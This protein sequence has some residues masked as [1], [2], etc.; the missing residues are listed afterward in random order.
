[1]SHRERVVEVKIIELDI[2][3][4]KYAVFRC[5][6][7]TSPLADDPCQPRLEGIPAMTT[8]IVHSLSTNAMADKSHP[9]NILAVPFKQMVNADAFVVIKEKCYKRIPDG[10][11]EATTEEYASI[12]GAE[13]AGK[14]V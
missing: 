9:E 1:M 11:R 5:L 6:L 14:R 8:E 3:T 12:L 7:T 13:I 2:N 10:F 4:N